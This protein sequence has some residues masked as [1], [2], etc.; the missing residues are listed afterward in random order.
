MTQFCPTC[1]DYRATKTEEREETYTV[2]GREI[3]VPVKTAVC[4]ECGESLGSDDEDEKVLG[5]VHEAYRR[6]EDLL[7]PEQIKQIRKRYRLSQKSF[8]ALLRMSEATINRYEKG[9]LQD[10]AHDTAIRACEDPG[11]VRDLLRRRGHMLSQWQKQRAEEALAGQAPPESDVP[12]WLD[13][14]E[15][16]FMP[17]EV[18]DRT[19]FRRFDQKRFAAVVVWFCHRLN[20]VSRTVINKLVFY[21]DF[22]NFRTATVSLTGSAYR[23]A[24]YGPVPTDY[25]LMLDWME[26]AELLVCDEVAYPNGYT[27]YDY[28]TGPK[29]KSLEVEFTAHERA[30]LEHV[31]GELGTLTA[32]AISDRSHKE[33]AWQNTEEKIIS[34]REAM[35]LSLSLPE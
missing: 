16:G 9:A 13:E 28:Q 26:A 20:R 4:A 32:K 8:A 18:S 27:G 19:G 7:T 10:Q 15:L 33:P 31:A 21:A 25:G 34:Y 12:D 6:E 11:L 29:A 23:K 35:S 24:Q 2:R 22:L 3:T 14:R 17:K 30:V 5:A 1:E